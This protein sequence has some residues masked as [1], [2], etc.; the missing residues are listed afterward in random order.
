MDLRGTLAFVRSLEKELALV[1]V[2]GSSG[3]RETLEAFF[4]T[5][6]VRVT[7]ARTASG[8]PSGLAVLS[9]DDEVLTTADAGRL[10]RLVSDA[11][12]DDRSTGV[13]DAAHEGVLSHLKETTFS[14][15]ETRDMLYASR[16]VEDRARRHGRGTIHAGFQRCSNIVDQSAIYSDLAR[17]GLTVHA[18]GRPDVPPPDLAGGRV[19][20]TTAD[21]IGDTWFV[22][23]DGGGTASQKSALLAEERSPGV[24]DGIWTY[25]GAIVDRLCAHL[26]RTY[27]T[28]RGPRA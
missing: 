28:N 13:S 12:F 26:E 14:S 7:T 9:T 24:Y 4:R 27:L 1:N 3:L 20:A 22:V 5:Q 10:R 11:Q 25:D 8:R 19:H 15:S 18:Y 23:F 16:E 17:E 6:N 2:E 21:E